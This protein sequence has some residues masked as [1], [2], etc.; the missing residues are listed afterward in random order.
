MMSKKDDNLSNQSRELD[1]LQRQV[2]SLKENFKASSSTK[3]VYE[4][5]EKLIIDLEDRIKTLQNENH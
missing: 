1:L 3:S 4:E 5:R 2:D